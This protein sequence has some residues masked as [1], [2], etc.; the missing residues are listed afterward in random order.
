MRVSFQHWGTFS[1]NFAGDPANLVYGGTTVP[2]TSMLPDTM[3]QQCP[4]VQPLVMVTL[5]PIL[6]KAGTQRHETVEFSF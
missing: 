3:S 1:T 2:G 5:S 6:Q 4:S